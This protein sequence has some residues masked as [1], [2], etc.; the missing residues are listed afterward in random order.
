[1]AYCVTAVALRA[2]LK[3]SWNRGIK[4]LFNSFCC[5]ASCVEYSKPE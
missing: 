1:M 3:H 4:T 2:S 5:K